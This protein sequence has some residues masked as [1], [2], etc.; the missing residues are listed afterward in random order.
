MKSWL[1]FARFGGFSD[2]LTPSCALG[3]LGPLVIR[4]TNAN[5]AA[6]SK[7]NEIV[8][9]CKQCSKDDL[10]ATQQITNLTRQD[11][12]EL[13]CD[14]LMQPRCIRDMSWVCVKLVWPLQ[15]QI[16]W[17]KQ[18]SELF[19]ASLEHF[20]TGGTLLFLFLIPPMPGN[21]QML[22][23]SN[24]CASQCKC[25]TSNTIET[26]KIMFKQFISNWCLLVLGTA[27]L[28]FPH[29]RNSVCEILHSLD[30][31]ALMFLLPFSR[32]TASKLR[33]PKRFA[34]WRNLKVLRCS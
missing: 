28:F 13:V 33:W 25:Y 17:A 27:T 12:N 8:K 4:Y 11:F 24:N 26:F 15:C 7:H 31:P 19:W 1:H 2:D 10:V 3:P 34:S 30:H 23:S 5:T 21:Y 18:E 32:E 22:A 9:L 16:G 6:S 14:W 29:S 20:Q